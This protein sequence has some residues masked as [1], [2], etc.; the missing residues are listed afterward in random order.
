MYTKEWYPCLKRRRKKRIVAVHKAF[1]VL[2]NIK[3]VG[4]KKK[5]IVKEAFCLK[6]WVSEW[7]LW[8]RSLYVLR[9]IR[10]RFFFF[11]LQNFFFLLFTPLNITLLSC[12]LFFFSSLV[13]AFFFSSSS[14]P[15][16]RTSTRGEKKMLSEKKKSYNQT[17]PPRQ[18]P[19]IFF[20]L[21]LSS[22][23][24]HPP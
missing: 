15:P 13:L 23:A 2:Q 3:M 1:M 9:L 7:E 8:C 17:N 21:S 6:E 14:S 10:R 11:S 18:P 22:L 5:C 24:I 12:L 4:A 20:S 16:H 19:N